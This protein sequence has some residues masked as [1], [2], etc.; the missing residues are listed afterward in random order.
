[1]I[2]LIE[3][4]TAPAKRRAGILMLSPSNVGPS[5]TQAVVEM[6]TTLSPGMTVKTNV[7]W[8]LVA[9]DTRRIPMKG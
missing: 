6:P 3:Q 7:N 9:I 5:Y 4:V 2:I 8:A 1:M